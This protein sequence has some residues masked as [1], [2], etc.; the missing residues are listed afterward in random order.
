MPA[1][2]R[3]G[4]RISVTRIPPTRPP[5]RHISPE[6]GLDTK[7][8]NDVPTGTTAAKVLDVISSD[9]AKRLYANSSRF[10]VFLLHDIKDYHTLVDAKLYLARIHQE[11]V[12][13]GKVPIYLARAKL[14]QILDALKITPNC[15]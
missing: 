15:L 4:E 6:I 10:V 7:W 14:E 8:W 13:T 9:R 12:A 11:F 3:S 2:D 1:D 5:L